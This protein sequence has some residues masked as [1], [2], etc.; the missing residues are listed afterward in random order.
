MKKTI[1]AILCAVI[2]IGYAPDAG[3]VSVGKKASDIVSS[4]K[5]RISE[6]EERNKKINDMPD[7]VFVMSEH[8]D[9]TNI[10]GLYVTKTGDI[11]MYDFRSIAPDEI[12]EIPD[13]Y[14][15]LEEATCDRLDPPE[16]NEVYGDWYKYNDSLTSDSLG[17]VDINDLV[18]SYNVLCSLSNDVEK[19]DTY[20]NLPEPTPYYEYYGVRKNG[21][22]TEI[23]LFGGGANT[24]NY[25]F[26][27]KDMNES[28]YDLLCEV[29]RWFPM[30]PIY[31]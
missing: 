8:V 17:K 10:C 26:A 29:S 2:L 15:R 19:Y 3:A 5:E 11:K 12:Y 31:E 18:K 23:V 27:D 28:A 7:I 14:D 13:V 22:N 4:V 30:I 1:T 21:D 20:F 25:G 16:Y 24:Y 6:R 9:N